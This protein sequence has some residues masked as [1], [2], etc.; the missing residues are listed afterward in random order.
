MSR[1]MAYI[2]K[3]KVLQI[4]T[5]QSVR[6]LES[7]KNSQDSDHNL[8]LSVESLMMVIYNSPSCYIPI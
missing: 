3:I 5:S 8:S 7:Q 1:Y 6:I 2:G 4:G